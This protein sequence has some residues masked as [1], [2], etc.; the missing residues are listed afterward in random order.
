M[1]VCDVWYLINDFVLIWKDVIIFIYLKFYLIIELII[2]LI[3]FY[4]VVYLWYLCY[5]IIKIDILKCS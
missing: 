3:F 2:R 1:K 4:L 5:V